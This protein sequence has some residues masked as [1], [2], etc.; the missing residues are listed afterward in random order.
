MDKIAGVGVDLAKNVMQIHAVDANERV[1]TRKAISR[2]PFMSWFARLE[3]CLMAVARAAPPI[4]FISGPTCLR[5]IAKPSRRS[6][7]TNMRADKRTLQM[8]FVNAALPN[9]SNR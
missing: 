4:H 1:V 5:P 6:I 8:Q 7:R 9:A 2:E 3:P